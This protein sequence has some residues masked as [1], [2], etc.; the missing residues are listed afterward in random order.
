[1]KYRKRR[2]WKYRPTLTEIVVKLLKERRPQIIANILRHNA[3]LRQLQAQRE[4][5]AALVSQEA[6]IS[7][8][9]IGVGPGSSPGCPRPPS[10]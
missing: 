6:G 10:R 5:H 3:L 8:A 2:P 1:M 9:L 4:D 7:D